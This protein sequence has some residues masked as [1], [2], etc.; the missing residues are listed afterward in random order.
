MGIDTDKVG[1]TAENKLVSHE[2]S[3]GADRVSGKTRLLQ[4]DILRGVAILLVISFH[5]VSLYGTNGVLKVG[6]AGW[7]RPLAQILGTVGWTGVDLFFVLSGFLIGG[8]LFKE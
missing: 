7:L 4:L 8:L 1:N 2:L 3:N 5:F 6:S